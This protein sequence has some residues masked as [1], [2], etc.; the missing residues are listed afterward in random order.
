MFALESL[1]PTRTEADQT[2][3]AQVQSGPLEARDHHVADVV[4]SLIP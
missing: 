1:G 4:S 3:D 2:Q